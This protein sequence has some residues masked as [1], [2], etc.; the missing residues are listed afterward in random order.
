M[1]G[2]QDGC[3]WRDFRYQSISEYMQ[4]TKSQAL[5][6][7]E[8][9]KIPSKL[10]SGLIFRFLTTAV[11]KRMRGRSLFTAESLQEMISLRGRLRIRWSIGRAFVPSPSQLGR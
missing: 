1:E 8:L 11:M 9:L 7:R 4:P 6:S 5:N 10:A 2:N 3:R